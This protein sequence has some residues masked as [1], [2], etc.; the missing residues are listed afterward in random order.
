MIMVFVY[1]FTQLRLPIWLLWPALLIYRASITF[2]FV[3]NELVR[4]AIRNTP[5]IV[6]SSFRDIEVF[7]ESAHKEITHHILDGMNIATD[8]IK[9]DLEST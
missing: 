5:N 8:R 9:Y 4:T 7:G 6:K 3:T 2:M 1:S